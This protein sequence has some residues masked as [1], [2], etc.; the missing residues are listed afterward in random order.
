MDAIKFIN[1]KFR[2]RNLG[3][4]TT[5]HIHNGFNDFNDIVTYG[6]I[7]FSWSE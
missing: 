6:T 3:F 2:N 4:T 5:F 7:Y 1:E